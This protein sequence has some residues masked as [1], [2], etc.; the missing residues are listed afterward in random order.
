MLVPACPQPRHQQESHGALQPT[1]TAHVLSSTPLLV[2]LLQASA[3]A[4]GSLYVSAANTNVTFSV[5]TISSRECTQQHAALAAGAKVASCSRCPMLKPS[6]TYDVLLVLGD[7]SSAG[8]ITHVQ[9]GA[10][11]QHMTVC[12]WQIV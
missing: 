4:C 10:S 5:E 6:V 7:A 2:L 11:T 3:A 8:G 12:K 9:V 1:N